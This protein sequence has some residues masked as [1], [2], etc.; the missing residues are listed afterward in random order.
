M[1]DRKPEDIRPTARGYRIRELCEREGIG[2]S[3][4]WRWIRKGLLTTSRVGPKNG[5][6]VT[7]A[8][9]SR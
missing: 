1:S 8:K 3:T 2:R 6:R 7:Y 4:A 5:V 9:P